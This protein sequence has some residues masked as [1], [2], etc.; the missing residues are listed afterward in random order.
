MAQQP[1]TGSQVFERRNT[2]SSD[3]SICRIFT[4][5]MLHGSMQQGFINEHLNFDSKNVQRGLANLLPIVAHAFGPIFCR[6]GRIHK[7]P[8]KNTIQ[9]QATILATQL[10]LLQRFQLLS[11]CLMHFLTPELIDG[12][13]NLHF[14][15]QSMTLR[16][17][18]WFQERET[19]WK[20]K[21]W[22]LKIMVWKRRVFGFNDWRVFQCVSCQR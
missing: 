6:G 4:I 1:S 18:P 3:L 16:V 12:T 22:T 13:R 9:S 11:C 20:T 14:Q 17:L 5:S 8:E 21:I 19:P 2:T 15:C 7:R 10:L